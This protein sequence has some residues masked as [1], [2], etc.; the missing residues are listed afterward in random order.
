MKKLLF[1]I[2][3]LPCIMFGQTGTW[4]VAYGNGA[5]NY[6]PSGVGTHVYID[7]LTNDIY[8]YSTTWI[9]K[10]RGIDQITGTIAP[11]YTPGPG[12]SQFAINNASP[13]ELYRH[14]GSGIWQCINCIPDAGDGIN[15]SGNVIS[16][17]KPVVDSLELGEIEPYS[18]RFIAAKKNNVPLVVGFAGDSQF[19]QYQR[20]MQNFLSNE[21]GSTFKP[22]G[23][24]YCAASDQAANVQGFGFNTVTYTGS[25]TKPNT[26]T[27]TPPI[28]E[29]GLNGRYSEISAAGTITFATATRTEWTDV[30]KFQNIKIYTK[31]NGAAFTYSIDGGGS[32]SVT[33]LTHGG[34]NVTTITG[35]VNTSHSLVI[36]RTSGTLRV[37]GVSGYNTNP[38]NLTIHRFAQG[39]SSFESWSNRMSDTSYMSK[40]RTLFPVPQV[41]FFNLGSNDYLDAG[42]LDSLKKHVTRF[43]TKF[44]S[45]MPNTDLVLVTPLDQPNTPPIDMRTYRDA[46]KQIAKGFQNVKVC[47]MYDVFGDYQTATRNGLLEA[48][49]VHWSALGAKL[50]SPFLLNFLIPSSTSA[51]DLSDKSV[52]TIYYVERKFSGLANASNAAYVTQLA[53]ALRGSQRQPWPDPW[54]AKRQATIDIAAG[55]ITSALIYVGPGQVYSYGDS[56]AANNG[57]TDFAGTNTSVDYMVSSA[58]SA[59]ANLYGSNINYFFGTGSQVHNLCKK[60]QI[61]LFALGTG[62]TDLN[63]SVSGEGEFYSYYGECQSPTYD[64]LLFSVDNAKAN[65]VFKFSKIGQAQWMVFLMTKARS[66]VIKGDEVRT[67]GNVFLYTNNTTTSDSLNVYVEINNVFN[68]DTYWGSYCDFWY[69]YILKNRGPLTFVSKIGN[70]FSKE[71]GPIV[72]TNEKNNFH[73]YFLEYGNITHF[74]GSQGYHN[75][76]NDCMFNFSDALGLA[77]TEI[78]NKIVVKIGTMISDFTALNFGWNKAAATAYDNSLLFDCGNCQV[79]NPTYPALLITA[80]TVRKD[81]NNCIIRGNYSAAGYALQFAGGG[82][83]LIEA[84]LYGRNSNGAVFLNGI[85]NTLMLRGNI[86]ASGTNS[87]YATAAKTVKVIGSPPTNK[88][89]NGNVTQTISAYSVDSSVGW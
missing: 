18:G 45:Y 77:T 61:V 81:R 72:Y 89:V 74:I 47:N 39:S 14:I 70:F 22:N 79:R 30:E 15:F 75:A 84:A 11:L 9:L 49:S 16:L 17:D 50:A 3:F 7:R 76:A 83:T 48:D 32:V 38:G 5:P 56:L 53:K 23:P 19:D 31:A 69:F 35:L 8:T 82:H 37:Y 59:N 54:S 4:P 21:W 46:I 86:V 58:T 36:T 55:V 13:P 62:S 78:S 41:V 6:T 1:L 33:T 85:A 28:V 51:A 40:M 67:A 88:A 65:I 34:V 63:F 43:I 66:I 29:E 10:G 57:S 12:Q 25:W 2:F 64:N 26:I 44:K 71:S 60:Y 73:K 27:N 87:I 42:N 52:G 68:G 80:D 24:G 20:N